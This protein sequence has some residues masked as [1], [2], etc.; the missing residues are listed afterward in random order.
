[1]NHPSDFSGFREFERAGWESNTAD[2]DAAFARLTPQSAAPLLDAAAV[3]RGMRVLDVA[4]GPGYVAGLAAARG[5]IVTG[6]DFSAAMVEHA[7]RAQPG[8]HFQEGDAQALPFPDAS[9]D[10]VVMSYGMLHLPQPDL[11]IAEAAR[12]LV[13]GGTFAFTVWASPEQTIG[14]AII[15]D[16]VQEHGTADVGLPDGPPF[17]RFSDPLECERVLNNAGFAGIRVITVPLVW[18]FEK[19]DQLF[20][21][22][23]NAGVRTKAML[24]A[25]SPEAL[26]SIRVAV[27]EAASG[28]RRNGIVELPMPAVVA[29]GKK[30]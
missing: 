13:P 29:S 24:R 19:A 30:S 21:A 4:S 15:L 2:Y 14:F 28:Y 7:R 25:Q 17:F 23:Y 9:F 10:A 6:I 20:D 22:L 18:R 12:V 3:E 11:A 8:V 16:A 26:R 1:M 27:A 5:A